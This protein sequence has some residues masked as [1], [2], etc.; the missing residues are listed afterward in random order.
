[1][2]KR[3]LYLIR[4]GQYDNNANDH[5]G[6]TLN[7]VGRQQA[8]LTAQA[9]RELPISTIHCSSMRRAVETATIIAQVFNEIPPQPTDALWECVPSVP[10]R[11]AHYFGGRDVLSENALVECKENLDNFY[12]AHFK[13]ARG[14]E[15]HELV[16]CHGNVI[17]YLVSRTLGAPADVWAAMLIYNCGISRILIEAEHKRFVVTHNEFGHLPLDLQTE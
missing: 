14:E 3:Y 8:E 17:R 13:A 15:K 6:G 1:M 7:A 9:L 4:H 11:L 5:L 12:E 16:V 10:P 2:A